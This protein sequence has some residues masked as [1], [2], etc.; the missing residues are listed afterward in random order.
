MTATQPT[1][2]QIASFMSADMSETVC[3]V[4]LLKFKNKATYAPEAAEATENL[5]GL[6]AYLR[7]GAGVAQVLQKIGAKQHFGGP[8]NRFMIGDGD[9]DMVA[10][11]IY[12]TRQA[13]IEMPQREDYQAIHYHREAGLA[14][15]DLIETSPGIL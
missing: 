3:M 15:Q 13:F 10:L 1:P 12:P 7:Y 8:V 11:V 4:N 5:T 6:E 14:H 2:E 9:W